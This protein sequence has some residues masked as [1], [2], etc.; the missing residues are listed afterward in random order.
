MLYFLSFHLFFIVFCIF[1][2]CFPFYLLLSCF[3]FYLLLSVSRCQIMLDVQ[4]CNYVILESCEDLEKIPYETQRLNSALNTG[5]ST[6]FQ[7][8]LQ[9]KDPTFERLFRVDVSFKANSLLLFT[10]IAPFIGLR[11]LRP[12][13]CTGLNTLRYAL[14]QKS[15]NF[16]KNLKLFQKLSKLSENVS[17][18]CSNQWLVKSSKQWIVLC[19]KIKRSLSDRLSE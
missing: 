7:C 19:Y 12:T 8:T 10:L 5:L 4:L 3:I 14:T 17:M 11:G 9:C 2:S 6:L 13:V 15:A 18:S 1:L 16:P